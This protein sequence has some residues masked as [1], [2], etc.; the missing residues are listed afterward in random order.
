MKSFFEWF[1]ASTKV[2]RWILL[3]VI[4]MAF[5]C[6]AFSKILVTD[7][8]SFNDLAKTIICFVIGFVCIVISVIFI[9][10]RK[11]FFIV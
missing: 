2:K 10:K 11:V 1:K 5:T 8:I 4:G 9:Q 7:E 3:I 6:F